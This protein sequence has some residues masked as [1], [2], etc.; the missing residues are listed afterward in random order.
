MSGGD[1]IIHAIRDVEKARRDF[2]LFVVGFAVSI[3][4]LCAVVI[5]VVFAY[6][7]KGPCKLA[8]HGRACQALKPAMAAE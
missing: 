3:L 8:P 1:H 6:Q 2:R 5:Y 7:R 4:A